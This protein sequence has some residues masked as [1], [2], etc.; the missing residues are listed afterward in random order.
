MGRLTQSAPAAD[1][2]RIEWS[3][4]GQP[5]DSLALHPP[6]AEQPV[7]ADARFAALICTFAQ[8]LT[9]DPATSIDRDM[10]AAIARQTAATPDL[11][12]E[13]ADFLLLIER[14]LKL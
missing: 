8:W 10:L 6:D 3:V 1:I 14:A 13:R 12:P 5:A 9:R 2:G 7:S 11:P 4:N